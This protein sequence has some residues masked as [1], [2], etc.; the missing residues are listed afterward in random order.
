MVY[1]QILILTFTA[2]NQTWSTTKCW[3]WRLLS[4]TV[5]VYNKVF[6]MMLSVYNKPGRQ[7]NVDFDGYCLQQT[8]STTKSWF[9]S[10]AWS[11]LVYIIV[12]RFTMVDWLFPIISLISFCIIIHPFTIVDLLC[13]NITYFISFGIICRQV[14]IV[15]LLF[16]IICLISS[17]IYISFLIK[18]WSWIYCLNIIY[19]FDQLRYI[20]IYIM[21]TTNCSFWY[22]LF[23]TNLVYNH[24]FNF[25]FTQNLILMFIVCNN[26][27]LQQN[28]QVS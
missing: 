12:H 11:V 3:F 7:P 4:T 28:D 20:Y 21:F 19:M 22:L 26:R 13:P 8:W 15:D 25:G 23:T 9:L 14:M 10:F 24:I 18:L 2:C 6:I 17:G 27:G 5:M 16:H 1:N